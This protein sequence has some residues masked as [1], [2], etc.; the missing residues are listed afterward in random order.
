[1]KT[2][3]LEVELRPTTRK[4]IN[5]TEKNKEKNLSELYFKSANDKS[6][7]ALAEIIFAF[8]EVDGK[9]PFNGDINRVYD[10]IDDYKFEN[11]KTYNDIY[12]EIAEMVNEQG[13]FSMKM[14][15]EELAQALNN[16]LASLNME[17]TMKMAIEKVTTEIAAEEFKGYKA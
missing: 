16:P 8:G 6:E 17:E 2:G 9:S 4:I 5:L 3:K 14:T 13:F 1:M 10:F 15:K 11:K 12:K 7:K